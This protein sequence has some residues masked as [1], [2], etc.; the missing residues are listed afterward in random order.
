MKLSARWAA[1]MNHADLRWERPRLISSA[2]YRPRIWTGGSARCSG[3]AGEAE[4][5]EDRLIEPEDI[6]VIEATDLGAQLGLGNGR[7]LVDHETAWSVEAVSVVR[8]NRNAEEG[9]LR[10]IR[11]EHAD[12]D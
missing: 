8:F 9:G 4:E 6:L 11:G 3:G 5:D 2:S 12:R 10:R 7:D 1:G